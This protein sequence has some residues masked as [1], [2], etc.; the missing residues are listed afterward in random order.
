[1]LLIPLATLLFQDFLGSYS[2]FSFPYEL[3]NACLIPNM[4]FFFYCVS[5]KLIDNLGRINMFVVVGFPV[6]ADLFQSLQSLKEPC[7]ISFL[8]SRDRKLGT[9]TESGFECGFL[10]MISIITDKRSIFFLLRLFRTPLFSNFT[11][12][13]F[14]NYFLRV[15]EKQDTCLML[16]ANI[17]TLRSHL[18][19]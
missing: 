3:K 6:Q 1:M 18:L 15:E 2:P 19:I 12:C 17:L 11:A 13:R 16:H 10:V 8:P 4:I 9:G 7:T 14:V 5:V